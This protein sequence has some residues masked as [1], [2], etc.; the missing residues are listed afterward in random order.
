MEKNEIPGPPIMFSNFVLH[1][2]EVP[3]SCGPASA[4]MALKI[5]G[6][7]VPESELRKRMWTN[8]LMGTLYGFLRRA[9]ER[10]LM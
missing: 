10:Y 5:P 1:E 4:K 2:Q 9:Y 8:P 3:F 7:E 6:I